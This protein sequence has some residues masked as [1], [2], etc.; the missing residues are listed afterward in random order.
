MALCHY[1]TLSVLG[2]LQA[3]LPH[4]KRAGGGQEA[5]VTWPWLASVASYW[6]L[7]VASH[8]RPQAFVSPCRG[9]GLPLL[10]LAFCNSESKYKKIKQHKIANRGP[11]YI[12]S[13]VE[14]LSCSY[15]NTVLSFVWIWMVIIG[16]FKFCQKFSFWVLS[17]IKL[18]SFVAISVLSCHNLSFEFGHN[19]SMVFYHN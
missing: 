11:E 19:M 10:M 12:S 16:V 5:G 2:A 17:Q 7:L 6:L 8:S 15:Q 14:V 3:G 4:A 9:S 13:I 18:L 1:V